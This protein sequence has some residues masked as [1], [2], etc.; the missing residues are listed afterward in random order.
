MHDTKN[1]PVEGE[2]RIRL[3]LLLIPA[4][5]IILDQV[6]KQIVYDNLIIGRR[7]PVI[8]G[9][10]YIT[11]IQNPGSAFGLFADLSDPFRSL[12]L[13]SL[14]FIALGLVI[15]YSLKL[16]ARQFFLQVSLHMIFAG[17]IGNLIDRLVKGSVTDFI[18][19]RFWGWSFPAFNVADSA[20]VLGVF[21]LLFDTLFLSQSLNGDDKEKEDPA[22]DALTAAADMELSGPRP[23]EYPK[24]ESTALKE[25][26]VKNEE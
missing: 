18:L 4:V 6:T 25:D 16:H 3:F 5:L 24:G 21:F 22:A 10:F 13:A 1:I 14:A 26:K 11:H 15:Y 12:F 23:S 17:A 8:D 19:F 20:I 7:I 9:F 2:G